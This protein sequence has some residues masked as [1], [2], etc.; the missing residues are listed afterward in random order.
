MF[1]LD[2]TLADN[3]H[4][5]ARAFQVFVERHGLP[6]ITEA[7]RRRIDGKRN[8]EIMP[9]LFERPLSVDEVTTLAWEKEELYRAM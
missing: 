1:D 6:P 7:T 8:A 9:I 5:H 3:M 2:G 4:W